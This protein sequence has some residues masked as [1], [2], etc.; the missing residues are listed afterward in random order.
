[1]TKKTIGETETCELVYDN[2]EKTLQLIE[3]ETTVLLTAN[4]FHETSDDVAILSGFNTANKPLAE[5]ITAMVD[6]YL[7]K[8]KLKFKLFCFPPNDYQAEFF[9]HNQKYKLNAT[10]CIMLRN[11]SSTQMTAKNK[12]DEEFKVRL[13]NEETD[14]IIDQVTQLLRNHSHW[15]QD[16]NNDGIEDDL[17]LSECIYATNTEEKVIGIVEFFSNKQIAYISDVVV[18]EGYRN[19]HIGSHLMLAAC[20][21]IDEQNHQLT[22]LLNAALG[23]KEAATKMYTQFGFTQHTPG[24]DLKICYTSESS[25]TRATSPFYIPNSQYREVHPAVAEDESDKIGY[26]I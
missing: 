6:S 20:N 18:A 16:V 12:I 26:T 14:D 25:P 1:M 21:L 2:F 13:I 11:K 24:A 22:F 9:T 17:K 4:F 23:S 8:N 5:L 7:K 15:A 3:N 19:K 10:D